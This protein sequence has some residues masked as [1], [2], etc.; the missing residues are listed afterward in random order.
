MRRKDREVTGLENLLAIIRQCQVGHLGMCQE[1][2]P[3]VLPLNFG[4]EL[5]EGSIVLYFHGA[6]E[7]RKLEVLRENPQVCVEF[8]LLHR[9]LTGPV[10]CAYSCT[11][12]SVVGFGRA[13]ILEDHAAKARGLAAIHRQTTGQEFSFT[14]EQT[15]TVAVIRVALTEVTGK[16]RP[17]NPGAPE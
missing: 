12:E 5:E 13:E 6:K 3:Y 7:G 11:F 17:E 4:A 2:R 1:G 8:E 9:L 10:A 14:P 15:D 16:R